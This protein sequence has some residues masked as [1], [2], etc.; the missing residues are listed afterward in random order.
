MPFKLQLKGEIPVKLVRHFLN[1]EVRRKGEALLLESYE[2]IGLLQTKGSK[3]I[4]QSASIINE[5][6]RLKKS[7]D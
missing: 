7:N 6:I 2:D 1:L 4:K 5:E 3:N